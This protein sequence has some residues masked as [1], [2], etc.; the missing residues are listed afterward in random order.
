MQTLKADVLH[1]QGLIDGVEHIVHGY[2]KLVLGKA[3]GDVG[4]RV[5]TYVGIDAKAHIGHHAL[6][7]SQ[8][9]DH[10]QLGYALHVEAED[11]VVEPKVNLPIA[12]THTRIDYFA[13]RETST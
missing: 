11:V 2:A 5:G 10:L 13:G 12:L 6:L 9:V 4:M 8:L 1:G 7:R 3:R